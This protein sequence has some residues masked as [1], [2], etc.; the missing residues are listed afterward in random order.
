M[1]PKGAD[2]R[3]PASGSGEIK[4]GAGRSFFTTRWSLGGRK[5]GGEGIDGGDRRRQSEIKVGGGELSWKR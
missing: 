3:R 1:A 2:S 4:R 5:S